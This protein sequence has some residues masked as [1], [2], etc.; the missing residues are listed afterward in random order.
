[1]FLNSRKNFIDYSYNSELKIF[2]IK[3]LFR[4]YK[5]KKNPE[6]FICCRQICNIVFF[7]PLPLNCWIV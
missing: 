3:V 6:F 2:I 7:C 4:S 5:S 1:M